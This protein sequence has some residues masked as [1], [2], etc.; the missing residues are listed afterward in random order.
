R[1]HD[2]ALVLGV[3]SAFGRGDEARAELGASVTQSQ[4]RYE[5]RRVADPSRAHQR[6]AQVTQLLDELRGAART[7]VTAGA[8]VHG[9]EPAHTCLEPLQSPLALGDVVV[10]EAGDLTHA[11]H[12]PARLAERR[13]EEPDAL[14]QRDVHPTLHAIEVQP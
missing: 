6:D 14:L 8:A 7:R 11:L 10:D 3:G 5:P 4:R 13:D 1:L 2:G 12:D 9:D